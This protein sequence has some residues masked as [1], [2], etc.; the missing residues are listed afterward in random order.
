LNKHL[1]NI[2]NQN[3]INNNLNS[4]IS[5]LLLKGIATSTAETK[6]LISQIEA[7]KRCEKKLSTWF[8]TNNIYYPNK[9]NIEQT[10]SEITA[11]YK[12]VLVSG[13]TLI[14]V[15][16]GFGV[17]CFYFSKQIREVYHCEINEK[18]SQIVEHNYRQLNIDN[19]TCLS[20]S[21]ITILEE[22]KMNYDWIYIDPS[23]RDDVKGKVFL[24]KDC[25]PNVP[26]HLSLLFKHSKNILIKTSPLLDIS[27]GISE[28]KHVKTIHSVAVN[29][30]VKELLWVLE[31]DYIGETEI[32]TVN[33]TKN[34]KQVFN[35]TLLEESVAS[36]LLSEPLSYLYEPN[37]AILKS[38]AFEVLAV[39]LKLKKLHKHSHLYT[40]KELIDFPGRCFKI[41]NVVEYNK[42]K[43]KREF[44]GD[45]ANVT[46]RNFPESVQQIRKKLNL[47]DGGDDYLFF[48][49]INE[50]EKIVIICE[51]VKQ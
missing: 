12:A 26:E 14:D 20:K 41:N 23:R 9:L 27:S 31:Q 49:T 17:D 1:L 33:I 36:A 42:K 6:A 3:I 39:K 43:F 11:A 10:S 29:N 30:E 46:T 5:E 2:E 51:K 22:E 34:N 47:K 44:K 24:L 48:T 37:A 25:L 28:L 13:N 21:G 18:L 50:N 4:N 15:T 38:G 19:I 32:K 7:K 8:S 40:S 45:K 16:G 35:F